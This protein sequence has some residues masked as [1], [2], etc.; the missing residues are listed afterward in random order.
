VSRT[1]EEFERTLDELGLELVL[2]RPLFVLTNIPLDSRSRLHWA[3]WNRLH[4]L[5]LRQPRLGGPLGAA[6]FPLEVA[7]VTLC[8]EGPGTELVVCRKRRSR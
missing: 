6:L 4:S 1:L 5:L 8:R 7:L 2:R 3:F